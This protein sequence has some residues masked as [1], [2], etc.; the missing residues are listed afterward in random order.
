MAIKGRFAPSPSGWLHLGNLFSSL[1]AWLDARSA[2][3]PMLLRIEDLD[4]LRCKR[5]YAL[6]L[7]EDLRW[8]GLD[9]DEGPYWQS[10]RSG[11]YQSE[12]RRLERDHEIYPCF[13][14]RADRL[15][16]A[17]PHPGEEEKGQGSCPC[18]LLSRKERAEKA[19]TRAPAWKIAVPDETVSFTDGLYGPWSENLARGCG[20]VILRK[21]DGGYA[22]QLCVTVDDALM[23]VTRVVRGRDLLDS[24]PRQIWLQR[25]LG[26]ATPGYL[27]VPL[28]VAADGR[29]LSKR[30]EDVGSEEL[31]RRFGAAELTAFLAKMAGIR[32][33]T[34]LITPK[35]L[36]PLY[37][38]HLLTKNDVVIK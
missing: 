32:T 11:V 25:E 15:A 26:Y 27:H 14:S 6:R 31:K 10:E 30:E 2:G 21:A 38:E 7:M 20:D 34:E 37:S 18:R 17:A 23:G 3:G 22:Y 28:L 8:L 4:P 35:E 24:T 5:E 9:W 1:L 16:A 29:R 36:I 12:F 19:L 13:C 33:E